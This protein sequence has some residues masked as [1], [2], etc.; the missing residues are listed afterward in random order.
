M[1]SAKLYSSKISTLPLINESTKLQAVAEAFKVE[2]EGM[3]I[4]KVLEAIALKIGKENV[5]ASS[6]AESTLQLNETWLR[7]QTVK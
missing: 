7:V 3:G 1:K 2:F 6:L 4:A 5:G